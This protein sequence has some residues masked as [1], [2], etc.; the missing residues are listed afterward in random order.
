MSYAACGGL[1]GLHHFFNGFRVFT[2]SSTAL[3]S[4]C[5]HNHVVSRGL[6]GGLRSRLLLGLLSAHLYVPFLRA[7]IIKIDQ[8]LSNVTLRL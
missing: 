7:L 6:T 4:S 5:H 3:D 8:E 2:I 1:K